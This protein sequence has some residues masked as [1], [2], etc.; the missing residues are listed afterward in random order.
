V[1]HLIIQ[2]F[3]NRFSDANYLTASLFQMNRTRRTTAQLPV[4]AIIDGKEHHD[5]ITQN[6]AKY[7]IGE[8]GSVIAEVAHRDGWQQLN[9]SPLSKALLES[10][11]EHI[12]SH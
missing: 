2:I 1:K 10:I 8:D 11:C 12:A 6:D 4:R 9:G 7:G 5:R 3:G